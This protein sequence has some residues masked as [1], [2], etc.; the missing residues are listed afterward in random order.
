MKSKK[1]YPFNMTWFYHKAG[2]TSKPHGLWNYENI[3]IGYYY[4]HKYK[5]F[6]IQLKKI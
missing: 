4:M 2:Y 1:E 5:G 6:W 3:H